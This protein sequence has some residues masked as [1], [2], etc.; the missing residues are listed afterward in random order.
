MNQ[1]KEQVEAD[2]AAMEVSLQKVEEMNEQLGNKQ[3]ELEA[4]FNAMQ[5]FMNALQANF[6]LQFGWI[7]K[8]LDPTG[9]SSSIAFQ[10]MDHH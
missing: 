6:N 3:A 2:Q 10:T 1:L 5:T 8:K 9:K 7:R 4:K